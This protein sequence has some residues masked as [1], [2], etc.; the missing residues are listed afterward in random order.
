MADV[1]I[2]RLQIEAQMKLGIVVKWS[3]VIMLELMFDRPLHNV[4][5]RNEIK[6]HI[7]SHRVV[8]AKIVVIK[9]LVMDH[10]NAERDNLAGLP[11]EKEPDAVGHG[12]AEPAEV[13]FG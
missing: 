3:A 7:K 4:A 13:I 6:M 1:K 10:A 9:S 11:P 2:K 5:E 12:L 8:E